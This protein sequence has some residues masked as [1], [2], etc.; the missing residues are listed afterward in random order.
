MTARCSSRG[1]LNL[2]VLASLLGDDIPLQR[3]I[4]REFCR[5]ASLYSGDL[6]RAY[7]SQSCDGVWRVAHKLKSSARTV[8]ALGLGDLCDQLE[9]AGRDRDWVRVERC[10]PQVKPAL[11]AVNDFVGSDP[12]PH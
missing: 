5:S 11:L 3:E 12:F 2:E 1:P 4:L 6:D 10:Y 9:R 8:G 7:D